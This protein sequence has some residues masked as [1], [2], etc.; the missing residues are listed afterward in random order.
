MPPSGIQT[1]SS[2]LCG[3]TLSGLLLEIRHYRESRPTDSRN[4]DQHNPDYLLRYATM[5]NLDREI[6]ATLIKT[7]RITSW[8]MP[9]WGIQTERSPPHWS[10]HFG[11]L[12]EVCHHQESRPRDPRHT[13][14]HNPDYFL[15][16]AITRNPDREI[17]ATLINTIRIASWGMPSPRI[18]TERFLPHWSTQSG[19]LLEVCHHQKTRLWDSRHSDQHNPDY[20]LRYATIR[21]PDCEI[22]DTLINII[23]IT[24]WGMPPSGIQTVRF[25]PHADHHNPDNF[26]YLKAIIGKIKILAATKPVTTCAHHFYI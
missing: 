9:P 8:G 1:E 5:R 6:P 3:S 2:P 23:R 4:T 11:L 14:Q 17:P 7:I 13:D 10:T 24:A 21:N 25:L 22:P 18:Q 12:H 15:R 19:L 16:Y 20:F 26:S